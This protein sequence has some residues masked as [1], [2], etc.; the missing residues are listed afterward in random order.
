[1]SECYGT[2]SSTD[3]FLIGQ[4][5]PQLPNGKLPTG[6]DVLREIQ[7]KW[8]QNK[9]IKMFDLLSC[10]IPDKICDS[11]CSDNCKMKGDP[12]LRCTI[13][14]IIEQYKK[15]GIPYIDTHRIRKKCNELYEFYRRR[16]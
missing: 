2:R 5:N 12:N 4:E 9:W 11:N 13:W 7:G 15:A 16:I 14:K 6:R 1:M 8:S 10:P 3:H